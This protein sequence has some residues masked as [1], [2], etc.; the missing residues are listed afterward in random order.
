ML[1]YK[2]MNV[3]HDKIKLV[4]KLL[5]WNKKHLT[6]RSELTKN[7]IS[8]IFAPQFVIKAN[9][10]I[11]DGNYNNYFEFLNQ[12]RQTIQSL[13]YEVQEFIEGSDKIALPL[14]AMITRTDGGQEI[15]DAIMVI[16]FDSD[17]KINHWQEVYTKLKGP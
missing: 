11:Y 12:F 8:L 3:K 17:G 7:D 4:K 5:K 9:G 15:I 6:N 2:I 14:K 1:R 16:G 13:D 10:K